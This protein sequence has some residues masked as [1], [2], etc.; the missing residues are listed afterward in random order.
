MNWY[1]GIKTAMFRK[2]ASVTFY[3]GDGA[4]KISQSD[5]VLIIMRGIS[6]SGK[7]TLAKEIGRGGIILSTDD[8]WGPNYDF[9]PDYIAEA[10]FWNQGRA[11]EAMQNGVSPVVI[12]NTHVE[13]WEAKPYVEMAQ[14]HGYRVEIQ[15][16]QTPWRFDAEE[17]AKRNSHGVPLDVI[18]TMINKWHPNMTVDDII[19]S[20]KP[21]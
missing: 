12:D 16:S 18:E 19:N 17:L 1:F 20:E 10:H 11:D 14:K 7:S 3:A 9:D 5:K 13:A 21:S 6:G 8:F 15:E 2:K 4:E